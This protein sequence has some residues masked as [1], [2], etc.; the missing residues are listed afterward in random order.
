MA[1]INPFLIPN[2]IQEIF[3]H[4]PARELENN[5]RVCTIWDDEAARALKKRRLVSFRCVDEV[6]VYLTA[7]RKTRQFPHVRFQ[8]L[9]DDVTGLVNEVMQEF[10]TI[11][12]SKVRH[13]ELNQ[14]NLFWRDFALLTCDGKL[15]KLISLHMKRL[16]LH[17]WNERSFSPSQHQIP[18]LKVLKLESIPE[19]EIGVNGATQRLAD[20]L[21]LFPN[22]EQLIFF[23]IQQNGTRITRRM[24]DIMSSLL[25]QDEIQLPKLKTIGTNLTLDNE[26]TLMMANKKFALNNLQ[27]S[28][29]NDV[30]I[31]SLA[32]LFQSLESSLA[33]LKVMLP[34]NIQFHRFEEFNGC[35]KKLS[36]LQSLEITKLDRKLT[37]IYGM[38]AL[39][40]L[41]VGTR[42][43]DNILP[44][45]IR[46]GELQITDLNICS[47]E[48]EQIIDGIN[49]IRLRFPMLSR[50]SLNGVD[51]DALRVIYGYLPLITSLELADSAITDQGI[52]GVPNEI[53]LEYNRVFPKPS[54]KDTIRD[55]RRDLYVGSM[56]FLV[57][58]SISAPDLTDATIA[59][60]LIECKKMRKLKLSSSKISDDGMLLLVDEMQHQLN[61][62]DVSLCPRITELSVIYAKERL[63][64]DLMVAESVDVS[65]E[66]VLKKTLEESDI[67][68]IELKRYM[69]INRS[70]VDHRGHPSEFFIEVSRPLHWISRFPTGSPFEYQGYKKRITKALHRNPGLMS[71]LKRTGYKRF[72]ITFGQGIKN[73][74]H[75]QV[76]QQNINNIN[77]QDSN[78]YEYGEELIPES[79]IVKLYKVGLFLNDVQQWLFS[80]ADYQLLD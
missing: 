66:K 26:K 72:V 30:K 40:K 4:L 62:V 59:Y 20:L 33:E 18:T 11:F 45:G 48:T 64:A 27:I 69:S 67:G 1:G 43:M 38:P 53:C 13:L 68:Q 46:Y 63:N 58:L 5:R 35:F 76:H 70:R 29:Q 36:N 79:T 78:E 61:Y 16:P 54:T 50:L 57:R 32:L 52:T 21:L 49:Q 3:N 47:M 31:E 42:N 74:I 39:R 2:V 7:M 34:R 12:G 75:G 44:A 6:K 71:M 80:G 9:F 28:F 77:N 41:V 51:D 73:E 56:Q 22:L 55:Y 23:P 37:F 15:P 10:W 17:M 25:L 65:H 60:G 19:A 14:S 24:S 8:F